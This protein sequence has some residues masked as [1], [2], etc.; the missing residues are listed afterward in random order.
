M[1]TMEENI[2]DWAHCIIELTDDTSLDVLTIMAKIK[3]AAQE[4]LRALE[5]G[6]TD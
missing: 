1:R 6:D 3:R 2:A 4:I 5:D